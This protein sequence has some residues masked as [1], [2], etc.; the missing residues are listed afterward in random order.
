M[1]LLSG[2]GINNIKD[3][4]DLAHC[5]LLFR[6]SSIVRSV[7]DIAHMLGMRTIA[8]FVEDSES[9]AYLVE[10]GVDYAQG[11]GIDKPR[12]LRYATVSE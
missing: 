7:N 4:R 3:K 8:E 6:N 11:Y 5:S 12:P 1:E 9:L 2:S 10:M